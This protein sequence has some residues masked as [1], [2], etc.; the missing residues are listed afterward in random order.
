M[1]HIH[2]GEGG[3]GGGCQRRGEGVHCLTLNWHYP[4]PNEFLTKVGS[5]TE[6]H[7]HVARHNS[8]NSEV[9]SC[10]KVAVAV[11]GSPSPTV[12]TVC[13]HAKQH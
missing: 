12:P 6:N 7:A 1:D 3:G 13:V 8:E 11:Q 5:R 10:V 9:R 4:N 2:K